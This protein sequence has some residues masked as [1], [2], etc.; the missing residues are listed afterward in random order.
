MWGT[1]YRAVGEY[2]TEACFVLLRTT[3]EKWV[4]LKYVPEETK[5]PAVGW[6][7]KFCQCSCFLVA[8]V[9]FGGY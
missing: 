8:L 5:V 4:L 7:C 3:D 9:W 6:A 1:D 2:L